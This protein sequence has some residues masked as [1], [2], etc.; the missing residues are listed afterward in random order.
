MRTSK[1]ILMELFWHFVGWGISFALIY[2]LATDNLWLCFF[3]SSASSTA[4][5]AITNTKRDILEMILPM[6]RSYDDN[7]NS[8]YEKSQSQEEQIE[9]L[10]E[11][12]AELQSRLDDLED[13]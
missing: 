13:D 5:F 9:E 3:I 11:F 7:I 2:W 4:Q 1:Q 10:K 8:L 6:A 12:V